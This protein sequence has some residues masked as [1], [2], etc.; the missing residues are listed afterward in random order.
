[1]ISLSRDGRQILLCMLCPN[2]SSAFFNNFKSGRAAR[3]GAANRPTQFFFGMAEIEYKQKSNWIRSCKDG[4]CLLDWNGIWYG[5]PSVYFLFQKSSFP[6]NIFFKGPKYYPS[7]SWCDSKTTKSYQGTDKTS[8]VHV[9][10][11]DVSSMSLHC[12]SSDFL[13]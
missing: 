3:A 5:S 11:V 1:M 9:A 13:L 8:H 6:S 12:K 2:N 4:C 7:I 10:T